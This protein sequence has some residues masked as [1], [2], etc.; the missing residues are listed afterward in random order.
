[1]RGL[2][3]GLAVIAV[4]LSGSAGAAP[5]APTRP[6][7]EFRWDAPAGCPPEAEVVAE[8][9]RL[10]GG[11]LAERTGSRLTAIARVRPEPGVGFDLK[12][13]TVGDA[14]TLQRSLTHPECDALARAGALIAA[15]AIDPSVLDRMSEETE[16]LEV[17]AGAKTLENPEPL[18]DPEL[19]K[20]EDERVEPPAP[21]PTPP[22]PPV[23]KRK[24]LRGGMRIGAG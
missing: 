23:K 3:S 24:Q 8:L 19:E 1:M 6:A 16:T 21:P 7:V 20:V 10:L 17:A 4:L 11:P 22:V 14:G 12:L 5:A 15:M 9:E 13:W 2:Y 18:P